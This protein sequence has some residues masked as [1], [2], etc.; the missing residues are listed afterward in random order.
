MICGNR[1]VISIRV[2]QLFVDDNYA[3]AMLKFSPKKNDVS[4]FDRIAQALMSDYSKQ[5]INQ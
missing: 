4:E 5:I 2:F 1:T 3:L